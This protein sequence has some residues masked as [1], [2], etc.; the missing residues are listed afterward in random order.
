MKVNVR[1]STVIDAPVARV[2]EVLRDYNG[3]DR[4]HPAVADSVLEHNQASDMIGAVRSFHLTSGEHLREQLLSM[5]DHDFSFSYC[6]VQSPIP[7]NEYVAH[8][9]LIPITDGNATYWEW[10]S[11]FVAPDGREAELGELVGDGVYSAGFEAI[12]VM[13]GGAR[14][15]KISPPMAPIRTTEQL[16][17]TEMPTRSPVRSPEP[18]DPLESMRPAI[19]SSG[20]DIEAAAIILSQHG[21]P[22][23][24]VSR[25]IFVP[26]PNGDEVRIQHRA[27]GVNYIDVYCRT[28]LFDL[29]DL[30]GI[31][32]LEAS[33]VV[34]DVGPNVSRFKPGDRVAYACVPPGAYCSAR[35]LPSDRLVKLPDGVTDEIAAASLVK[36][37]TAEFLL[38]R[39]HRL[40]RGETVLVHAAAGGVG[41]LLTQWASALGAVVIGTVGSEDKAALAMGNGCAAVINYREQNFVTE[42]ARLT[43][44]RGVDLVVDG[45]GQETFAGS[46][47]SLADCGHLISYGQAS[48]RIGQWDIDAMA[49]KSMTISRPNFGHYT[50]TRSKLEAGSER[51]FA[52]IAQGIVQPQIGR[53]FPL[54]EAA[55]AHRWLE[56]RE[57]TGSNLLLP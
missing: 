29:I 50:D 38:H 13:L 5:S 27:I 31:P 28:G 8:V 19:A 14:P 41:S 54:S 48:G 44:G 36:G 3:H 53:Q 43:D 30:P 55:D 39:V 47:E 6:I 18:P 12:R 49:G 17:V 1:R 52:A 45:V 11:S 33:G 42:V 57:S 32:G 20:S 34:I 23:T 25:S 35:N 51:L 40:E 9:R 21:G 37:L 56:S 26:P 22:E 46:A 10:L 2:W 4:W 24:L 16:P 15:A 7:L